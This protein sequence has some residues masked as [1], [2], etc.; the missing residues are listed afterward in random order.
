MKK[1]ARTIVIDR[2]EVVHETAYTRMVVRHYTD[3]AGTPH[4]WEMIAL[5]TRGPAS[6][7]AAITADRQIILERTYRIPLRTEVIELPGGCDDI[8]GE[9]GAQIAAR[10]LREETG[11]EVGSI[12]FLTHVTTDPGCTD[13]SA[14][15]FLG[16]DAEKKANVALGPAEIITTVLVPLDTLFEYLAHSDAPVDPKVW[17]AYAFLKERRLIS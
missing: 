17:V 7:I 11:F 4:V 5:N 13:S 3:T 12:E 1:H 14:N 15:L 6:V 10:E 2:D 9:S 16:L 8:G